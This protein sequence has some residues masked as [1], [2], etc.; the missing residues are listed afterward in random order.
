MDAVTAVTFTW[1]LIFAILFNFVTSC[2]HRP[3]N[4]TSKRYII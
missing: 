4:V 3:L 2:E 1:L